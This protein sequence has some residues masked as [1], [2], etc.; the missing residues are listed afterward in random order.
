MKNNVNLKS[1][2]T[3]ILFGC[4]IDFIYTLTFDIVILKTTYNVY[5]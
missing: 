1:H 4:N 2:G 3:I 5:V